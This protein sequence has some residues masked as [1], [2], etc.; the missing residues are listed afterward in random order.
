MISTDL[1]END[2]TDANSEEARAIQPKH[3]SF[4]EPLSNVTSFDKNEEGKKNF[5]FKLNFCD[6]QISPVICF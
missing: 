3:L 2:S 4:T 1:E 6:F 5:K